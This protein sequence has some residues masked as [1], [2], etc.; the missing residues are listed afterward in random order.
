[1]KTIFRLFIIVMCFFMLITTYVNSALFED[2]KV[3]MEKVIIYLQILAGMDITQSADELEKETN[4]IGTGSIS[5]VYF[6]TGGALSQIFNNTGTL[7]SNQFTVESTPG[8][9]FNIDAVVN[10]DLDFAIA[11]SDKQYQAVKGI[12]DWEDDG[13]QYELRAMFSIY[14]ES[15]NLIASDDSGID[16]VS[17]LIG[18]KVY[19]GPELSGHR[20]NS[21]D[22]LD[23]FQIDYQNDLLIVE[24]D[25]SEPSELLARNEID[26]F[27]YTVGHPSQA[28]LSAINTNRVH[29]VP[30]EGDP[31]DNLV[32]NKSYYSKTSIPL[33]HYSGVSNDSEIQTIAV[34]ATLV[35][36]ARQSKNKI[37][38]MTKAI[39]ENLETFSYMHPAYEGIEPESMLEGLS[40]P[41][42]DGV[43]QYFYEMG[44]I[45]DTHI[46]TIGTGEIS[47]IYF[48]TGGAIS[49]IVNANIEQHGI[50]CS[51]ETTHGSVFNI[52]AV[53][54][55][56]M[57]FGLAQSDIQFQAIRGLAKWKEKRQE[58]KLRSV[59]SIHHEAV[60]LV[61]TE[62][63]GIKK[64][65]DLEG[66][67]VNISNSGSGPRKNCMDVLSAYGLDYQ[68]DMIA[69]EKTTAEAIELMKNGKID[70]FFYTVGH[71]N[72]AI[73]TVTNG[74]K[75]VRIIPINGPRLDNIIEQFPY[76]TK[77]TIPIKF[78]PNTINNTD[79]ETFGVKATFVTS[80]NMDANIVYTITKAIFENF[81]EFKGMHPAYQTLTKEDMLRALSAPIHPGAMKYYKEVGL[82][83][84]DKYII[85]TG[86][87]TGVYYPTGG[88]IAQLVNKTTDTHNIRLSIV[89]TP[90]S[91]YNI[92]NLM[93]H[94][95]EFGLVQSDTQYQAYYGFGEW[96]AVGAQES[97]R[98]VF[99]IYDESVTLIASEESG[100]QSV[101]DLSG[102]KVNLG[103]EGSGQLQN[104][105]DILTAFGIDIG[106]DLTPSY[107]H[108]SDAP[109][110]LQEG[111][112]DAFFL[113]AAH[114]N[115]IVTEAL[116]GE[117][118][119]N[120]IP[121]TGDEV[122][123]LISGYPYYAKTVIP[124]NTYAELN[125]DIE[126][127][128]VKATLMTT[129]DI[130]DD[131][132]Y[133]VCKQMFENLD[134][135]KTMHP[136]YASITR[137]N[138][139]EGLSAPVHPGALQYYQE[140]ELTSYHMF[141]IGTGN[142]SGV[143]YP[144]GANIAQV[145]NQNS[146][147]HK[148]YMKAAQSAG[149]VYNINAIVSGELD[150]GLAQ[151]DR[152]YQATMGEADWADDGPQEK[153]AAVFTLYPESVSQ[154]TLEP[155]QQKAIYFQ[156]KEIVW[157]QVRIKACL[158][159]S[160][161]GVCFYIPV[162]AIVKHRGGND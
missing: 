79:I 47:G 132:V 32:A 119:V 142:V 120:I 110:L 86:S 161:N 116:S 84:T 66:K 95:I 61:A 30:I 80:E 147:Q 82:I 131:I 64:V 108:V 150:F 38:E 85:G 98:S 59:F 128:A 45:S 7:D 73:G 109:R 43:Y 99:S 1:M 4:T 74:E 81:D 149:S 125:K 115:L 152:Q 107:H 58:K 126:T 138:M 52:D 122:L 106:Q 14:P 34:K 157:Q 155:G 146:N 24:N 75:K 159:L 35:T 51:V 19:I 68:T 55:G 129:S 33:W 124:Q 60:T 151:S 77:C 97:L 141:K 123:G 6:P 40:D 143:Y 113:T 135:F 136:A 144:T 71:P 62:E 76:Y 139:L 11:Q 57:D 12:A 154:N 121:I 13:P 41:L 42:H 3:T 114:T 31:I 39:F 18:K 117:K 148:I 90:G 96:N 10:G 102:K 145:I 70:A 134:T 160:G 54:S 72:S 112:I 23:A 94:R 44:L 104:S 101:A 15:V 29:F 153:L 20:Q 88:A 127:I 83:T 87:I 67:R 69:F 53:L 49:S 46:I 105:I 89:S 50:E 100:I 103:N 130:P 16:S 63:S 26:A 137:E 22:I 37:Y 118:N 56:N 156:C 21:I 8:S 91:V 9:V 92:E 93:N 28:L 162:S 5:G 65:I 48:P 140:I 36:S 111:N 25:T 27:F 133:Y 78:Y 2:N 158:K 17:D